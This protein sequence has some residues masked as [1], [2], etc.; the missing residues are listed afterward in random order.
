MLCQLVVFFFLCSFV[1]VVA[2]VVV[3]LLKEDI[4]RVNDAFD[5]EM[6]NEGAIRSMAQANQSRIVWLSV[7]QISVLCII[8]AW[9]VYYLKSFFISKKIV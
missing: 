2:V 4:E 9:E 6:E 8:G 7:I 3:Q 5:V 1:C